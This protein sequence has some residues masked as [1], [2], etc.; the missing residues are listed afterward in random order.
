MCLGTPV[1]ISSYLCICNVKS[2]AL[3]TLTASF[4]IFGVRIDDV[5]TTAH[6]S[7]GGGSDI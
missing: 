3:L 5:P 2:K 4:W 6:S 1:P 7:L